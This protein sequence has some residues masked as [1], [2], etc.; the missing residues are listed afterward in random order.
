MAAE[1]PGACEP[2]VRTRSAQDFGAGLGA[3]VSLLDSSLLSPG[4]D[5]AAVGVCG[6]SPSSEVAGGADDLG[7]IEPRRAVS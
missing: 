7:V 3:E 1:L 2:F 5:E 4:A 6:S